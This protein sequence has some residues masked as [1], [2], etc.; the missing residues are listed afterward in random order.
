M[1]QQKMINFIYICTIQKKFKKM[2]KTH[3]FDGAFA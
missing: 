3:L 1:L 2:L